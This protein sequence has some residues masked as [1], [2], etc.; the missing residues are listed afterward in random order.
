MKKTLKFT[1]RR[2]YE[3]CKNLDAAFE[4]MEDVNGTWRIDGYD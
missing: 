3:I 2:I 4:D 1:Q